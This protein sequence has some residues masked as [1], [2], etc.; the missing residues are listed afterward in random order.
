M[1][2][3]KIIL[4]SICGILFSL[5]I[6]YRAEKILKK[7]MNNSSYKSFLGSALSVSGILLLGFLVYDSTNTDLIF[8]LISFFISCSAIILWI[9]LAR[10]SS[11][12]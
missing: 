7:S 4:F 3:I 1:I 6:Y 10:R 5:G 8:G 2:S 11:I 9:I 12:R